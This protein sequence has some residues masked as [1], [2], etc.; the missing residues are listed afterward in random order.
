MEAYEAL[1]GHD[2]F[3]VKVY[4]GKVSFDYIVIFPGSFDATED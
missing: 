4:D 3:A 2:E 1:N